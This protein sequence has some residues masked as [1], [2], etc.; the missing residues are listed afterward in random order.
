MAVPDLP[1]THPGV[2]ISLKYTN[3]K[4]SRRNICLDMSSFTSIKEERISYPRKNENKI[5][6]CCAADNPSA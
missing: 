3:T 1:A 2:K 4:E 5:N 6:N